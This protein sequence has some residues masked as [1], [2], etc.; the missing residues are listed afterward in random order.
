[1]RDYQERIYD[2]IITRKNWGGNNVVVNTENGI[3]KV[4]F[5][6]SL[7]GVIN[8][9]TK[10]Y[11]C[12]NCGYTNAATTARINAIKMACDDLEYKVTKKD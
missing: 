3:T 5:Y 7:I 9:G 4:W 6:G 10:T 11:K 1:M 8:H 12:D 2:G